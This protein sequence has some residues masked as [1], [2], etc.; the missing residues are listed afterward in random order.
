MWLFLHT[1]QT[2]HRESPELMDHF[3]LSIGR[4]RFGLLSKAPEDAESDEDQ[5]N[6]QI[7]AMIPCIDLSAS[8][9]SLL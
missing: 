4:Y 2:Y 8:T 5:G 7:K 1:F 3:V 6:L 9:L